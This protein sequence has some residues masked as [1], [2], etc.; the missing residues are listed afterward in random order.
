[1]WEEK[2]VFLS[3]RNYIL[4]TLQTYFLGFVQI[5]NKNLVK[6]YIFG[7]EVKNLGCEVVSRW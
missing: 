4:S 2:Y 1:M 7:N 6:Q 5:C 3:F